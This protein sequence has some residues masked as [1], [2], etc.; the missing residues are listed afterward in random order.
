MSF[1]MT[2][3]LRA[4]GPSVGIVFV[5]ASLARAPVMRAGNP[6]SCAWRYGRS[7]PPAATSPT[8]PQTRIG[9]R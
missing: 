1:S 2:T 4:A 8:V 3:S 5:V 9:L 6:H 7:D